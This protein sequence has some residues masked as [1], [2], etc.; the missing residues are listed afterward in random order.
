[1][2]GATL[3]PIKRTLG[4]AKFQSTLLMRGATVSMMLD[5]VELRAFQSTLLMRGATVVLLDVWAVVVGISIHAPHARSDEGL[6]KAAV[7]IKEFQSTLLM[8]GATDV[9]MHSRGE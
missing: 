4:R 7:F 2:R 5:V 8:R 3:R 1:M 9:A 6:S